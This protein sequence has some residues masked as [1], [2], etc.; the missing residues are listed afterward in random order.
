MGRIIKLKPKKKIKKPG[1]QERE[2]KVI[3]FEIYKQKITKNLK[4]L[5]KDKH[6]DYETF[7]KCR[8]LIATKLINH[9]NY[10]MDINLRYK[11]REFNTRLS[12]L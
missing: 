3:D 2:H 7:E 5:P 10:S 9:E 12:S 11:K 4:K 1:I 8:Q 6:L